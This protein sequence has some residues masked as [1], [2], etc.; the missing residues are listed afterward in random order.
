MTGLLNVKMARFVW[1]LEEKE[2]FF[3]TWNRREK[4]ITILQHTN[5]TNKSKCSR[6]ISHTI[7]QDWLFMHFRPFIMETKKNARNCISRNFRNIAFTL[8]KNCNGSA[9]VDTSMYVFEHI[10]HTCF[11]QCFQSFTGNFYIKPL[12]IMTNTNRK[13]LPLKR[14]PSGDEPLSPS[15]CPLRRCFPR[16][17]EQHES[18]RSQRARVAKCERCEVAEEAELSSTDLLSRTFRRGIKKFTWPR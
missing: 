10:Q 7:L 4:N 1:T 9:A 3:F 11:Q 6:E 13:H 5:V 17:Y 18:R 2:Y 12:D 8:R 15:R 16:L 14:F